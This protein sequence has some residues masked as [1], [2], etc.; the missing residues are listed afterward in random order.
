MEAPQVQYVRTRDGYDI[1]YCVSGNGVPLVYVPNP[2]SHIQLSWRTHGNYRL[3]FERLSARFKLI[4]Y[5]SRGLGSSTRGLSDAHRSED[6]EIDLET[7]IEHLGLQRFALMAQNSFG[8]VAMNYAARNPDRVLALILYNTDLGNVPQD[9]SFKPTQLEA[10]AMTNW[11][12]YV[13]TSCART[14]VLRTRIWQD[15]LFGIPRLHRT[16]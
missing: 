9:H 15:A 6:F 5:D 11:E 12:M 16:G 13:E 4:C 2:S 3:L 14:G 1:A 7:V 10:L 8:R